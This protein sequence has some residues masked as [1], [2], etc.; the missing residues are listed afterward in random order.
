MLDDEKAA[1]INAVTHL[2]ECTWL[3]ELIA[4]SNQHML[5]GLAVQD[6]IQLL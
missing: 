4:S 5:Q 2:D 3:Q 1:H 6:K